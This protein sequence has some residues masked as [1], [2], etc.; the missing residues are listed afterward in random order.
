MRSSFWNEATL[1]RL[2]KGKKTPTQLANER[3]V[4]RFRTLISDLKAKWRTEDRQ[5]QTHKNESEKAML[6]NEQK[7]RLRQL[8]HEH[9]R[10]TFRGY[11]KYETALA[12]V[13][14]MPQHKTEF[15]N[16]AATMA[17]FANERQQGRPSPAEFRAEILREQRAT[18][19]SY[20]QAFGLVAAR[21][22]CLQHPQF[23]NARAGMEGEGARRERIQELIKE[24][25]T[26]YGLN[27]AA[28]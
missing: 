23:S 5:E 6:S 27:L 28:C 15:G 13:L 12:E 9:L 10:N 22:P 25:C 20:E 2:N 16:I 3:D 11:D 19:L 21:Y 1:R 7:T 4:A 26:A 24:Y 18:G 17:E 14:A 8:V